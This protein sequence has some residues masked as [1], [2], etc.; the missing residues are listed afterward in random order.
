MFEVA[1]STNIIPD[2]NRSLRASGDDKRQ[3]I[4]FVALFRRRER[5]SLEQ[6]PRHLQM[7]EQR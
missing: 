2:E 3:A 7:H 5:G 4:M 1:E 6:L